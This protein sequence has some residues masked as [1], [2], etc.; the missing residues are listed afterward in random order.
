MD[1]QIWMTG[2]LLG[3][4]PLLKW[5][6]RSFNH[7]WYCYPHFKS[8]TGGQLP[9]GDMG[10]PIVGELL[11]FLWYF[12][13]TG[14]PDDFIWKRFAKYGNTGIYRTHMF[15]FPAI[16]TCSP[17]FNKFV[18]GRGTEDGSFVAGWPC[19]KLLGEQSITMVE[20]E[21][22]KRMRRS[23]LE[24]VNSPKSLQNI[25]IKL[26]PVFKETF[27]N[28]AV[29][30]EIHTADE[31]KSLAFGNICSL[32]LSFERSPMV[33]SMEKMYRGLLSGL[34]AHPIN[35]PGSA[36]HFALKCRRRLSAIVC[37][38]IHS[39]KVNKENMMADFLSNLMD[40]VDFNGKKLNEEEI[41]DNLTSMLL[42][43]YESTAS[44]MIWAIY[45]LSKYP[46]VLSKLK[47][48]NFTIKKEKGED[49]FLNYN[50]VKKMTYT[51]KVVDE[52]I[53]LANVAN[54]MFRTVSKDTKFKG[55]KFPKGW[56]VIVWLRS[57]HVDPQYFK[58]PLTFNPDRWDEFNLSSGV[59]NVFGHGSRQCP[60]NN[61]AKMQLLIFLHQIC[62][63]YKWHLVN[64]NEAT[65]FLPNPRLANGAKIIFSHV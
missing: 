19:P 54:F 42:A 49:K 25:F 51:L 27:E 18:M 2:F 34:R 57:L 55:Y 44:S 21:Q 32:F 30:G 61:L 3:L 9:P 40:L 56:K 35:I 11:S 50:D 63:D 59:Y 24:A 29:K 45:Y 22:H 33:E 6:L 8:N 14:K 7:W 4:I 62:V 31:L 48:E 52:V 13:F 65:K 10:W 60:G 28:W 43:G 39:R 23:L 41:V 36:F 58:D 20:G 53:R 64:P 37:S 17:E 12:K 1:T 16:I 5:V 47:E 15:S 38:E 46:N 26:Q